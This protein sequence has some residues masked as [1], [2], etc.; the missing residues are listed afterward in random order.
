MTAKH[1]L[2]EL[3]FQLLPYSG[4]TLTILGKPEL[5][6]KVFEVNLTLNDAKAKGAGVT[7]Q[8]DRELTIPIALEGLV[9]KVIFPPPYEYFH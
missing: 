3:G 9:E 4:V 6:E 7:V 5:F 1:K 2:Q 8:S